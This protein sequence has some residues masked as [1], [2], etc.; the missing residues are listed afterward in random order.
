M[1]INVT[2]SWVFSNLHSDFDAAASMGK[3]T[4]FLIDFFPS[5]FRAEL[6]AKPCEELAV[7]CLA[8]PEQ[9]WVASVNPGWG[10][11]A[12]SHMRAAGQGPNGSDALAN[13][14]TPAKKPLPGRLPPPAGSPA[15][16]LSGKVPGR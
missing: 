3:Y 4:E 16:E 14:A 9:A 10:G 8:D 1:Q 2:S 5:E 12:A 13:F 6:E 15:G 7:A 11:A